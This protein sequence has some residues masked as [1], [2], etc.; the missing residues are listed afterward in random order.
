MR[1]GSPEVP[2]AAE[3]Y[4]PTPRAEGGEVAGFSRLGEILGVED[5]VV[6]NWYARRTDFPRPVIERAPQTSPQ[7]GRPGMLFKVDEVVKWHQ[8]YKPGKPGRKPRMEDAVNEY[9]HQWPNGTVGVQHLWGPWY[10]KDARRGVKK[11][12]QYRQCQ[13]PLCG[14]VEYRETPDA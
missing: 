3:P 12:T 6:Y 2:G 8:N 13:H 9:Q 5:R 10:A 11:P 4:D 7:G 1:V 14:H